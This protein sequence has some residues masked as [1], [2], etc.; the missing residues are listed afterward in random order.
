MT[1]TINS[2]S[3]THPPLYKYANRPLC[4]QCHSNINQVPFFQQTMNPP[5]QIALPQIHLYPITSLSAGSI[6][7]YSPPI[8]SLN[9]NPTFWVEIDLQ[10]QSLVMNAFLDDRKSTFIIHSPD[11]LAY[12]ALKGMRRTMDLYNGHAWMAIVLQPPMNFQILSIPFFHIPTW[13][14]LTP[15]FN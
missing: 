8:A 14:T 5:S 4:S 12:L 1:Q 9:L 10:G 3:D 7:I 13:E 2:N 6:S 11:L 15:N